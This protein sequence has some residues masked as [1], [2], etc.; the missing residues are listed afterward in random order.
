ML[1]IVIAMVSTT[2]VIAGLEN[3]SSIQLYYYQSGETISVQAY[4][5][6]FSSQ[7]LDSGYLGYTSIVGGIAM[8]GSN[9]LYIAYAPN[10]AYVITR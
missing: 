10:G 9:N 6:S 8:N 5:N 2:F 1:A 3:I 7:R 4:A